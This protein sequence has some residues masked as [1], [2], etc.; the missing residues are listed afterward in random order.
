MEEKIELLKDLI[1]ISDLTPQVKLNTIMQ[2]LQKT[3]DILRAKMQSNN[4]MNGN[5]T[6][7]KEKAIQN[8]IEAFSKLNDIVL[9]NDNDIKEDKNNNS[10]GLEHELKTLK[11]KIESIE[12]NSEKKLKELEKKNKELEEEN[13][14]LF[15][16]LAITTNSKLIEVT[17]EEINELYIK[18]L[19]SGDTVHNNAFILNDIIPKTYYKINNIGGRK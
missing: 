3:D 11:L 9:E 8:L 17:D 4:I 19:K 16:K 7:L 13:N 2:N 12:Y 18:Y 14:K 5:F 1:A 15:D 6:G 10:V